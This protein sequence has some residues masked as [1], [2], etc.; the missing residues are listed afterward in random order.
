M[1]NCFTYHCPD[2]GAPTVTRDGKTF[3]LASAGQDAGEGR[4]RVACP[5]SEDHAGVVLEEARV[6]GH[7]VFV[8]EVE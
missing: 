3:R 6:A 1:R 4:F 5:E 7:S 2:C 8:G